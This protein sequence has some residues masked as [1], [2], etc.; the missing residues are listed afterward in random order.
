MEEIAAARKKAIPTN[1]VPPSEF[2]LA[3]H[4][5]AQGVRWIIDLLEESLA[6]DGAERRKRR[7]KRSK[8]T[9]LHGSED[10]G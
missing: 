2:A 7:K 9:G 4:A 5:A 3:V 10:P 6:E 8:M 1:N